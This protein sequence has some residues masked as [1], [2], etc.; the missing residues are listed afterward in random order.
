MKHARD[1]FVHALGISV[2]AGVGVA[3]WYEW[4]FSQAIILALF[5]LCAVVDLAA[6]R[7][8]LRRLS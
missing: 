5:T 4:T 7:D 8:E 2:V 6:L 1:I 3:G